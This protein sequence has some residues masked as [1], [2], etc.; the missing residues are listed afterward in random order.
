MNK[1][2]IAFF[3]ILSLF[4][5]TPII[6]V[7]AAAKAGAKCAKAGITEVVK[8]KSYTCVKTGKK[9]V[10]NKGVKG[11]K[12]APISLTRREKAFSEVKRVY[13][14]SSSYQP[15]VE[16]I[17]ASDAPQ[18]F[19]EVIKE[20]IPISARFWSSEFKPTTEFP[21]ILGSPASVEWVND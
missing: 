8:D 7:N 2:L 5:S 13:D 1:K 16:Y 17:F 15:T 12:V 3:S 14:L 9:L 19:A 6:P 4:L 11:V 21:I 18:N 10:W 20:V